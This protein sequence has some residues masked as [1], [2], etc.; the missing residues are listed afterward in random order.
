MTAP[1]TG[2]GN[3]PTVTGP[4]VVSSGWLAANSTFETR[5]ERRLGA[6]LGASMV[7]HAILLA[8]IIAAF[9][10]SPSNPLQAP[11][12]ILTF[13][14][15]PDPGP[16]GGGGGSP[17]PA[18]PKPMQ[19]A[20]HKAPDPPP[21]TPPPIEVPP[22]A[23]APP[24]LSAPIVTPNAQVMQATG[25]SN[26]SLQAYGGGGRGEGL[27][28]GRGSG[29]GPGTGGGFGDGVYGPGSGVKGPIALK[30][31]QPKYTTEAMRAKIQGKVLLE[32]IILKDG[33]VGDVRVVKSLDASTGLDQEAMKAARM[34][35]FQP[36]IDKQ[37]QPVPY[38][39]HLEL[40]FRI[41]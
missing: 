14:F 18:P 9:A 25:A 13:V 1:T 27:G 6:G 21:L 17:A 12:E 22:P 40:S 10:I 28:A 38:R 3:T 4:G 15:L 39:A 41:F 5:P 26:I 19:V 16:G 2:E 37:G 8:I 34:W 31:V 29:V 24:T 30:E 23:V 7:L 20:E 32:I 33:T 36:A 35:L 11:N